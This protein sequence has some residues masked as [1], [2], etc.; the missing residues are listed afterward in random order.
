MGEKLTTKEMFGKILESQ[1][2]AEARHEEAEARH[3]AAEARHK[4]LAEMFQQL[5]LIQLRGPTQTPPSPTFS[6]FEEVSPTASTAIV[7]TVANTDGATID[8]ITL[9]SLRL[10][11]VT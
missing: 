5:M 2:A 9:A 11:V 4:D 10:P 6:G 1:Q 8:V 3:Q 7:T